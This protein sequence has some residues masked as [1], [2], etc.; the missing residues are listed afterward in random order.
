QRVPHRDRLPQSDQGMF[1]PSALAEQPP[2]LAPEEAPLFRVR[3][4]RREVGQRHLVVDRWLRHC[5]RC[6]APDP[7]DLL[8]MQ[9]E[10]QLFP[11]LLHASSTSVR[12]RSRTAITAL[13]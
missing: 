7:L 9:A 8:S 11:C 3:G 2:D 6:L 12:A 5:A 4:A 13:R 10:N 1:A